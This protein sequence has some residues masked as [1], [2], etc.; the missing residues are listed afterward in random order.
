MS[1]RFIGCALLVAALV[2]CGSSNNETESGTGTAASSGTTGGGGGQACTDAEHPTPDGGCV[3]VAILS[4]DFDDVTVSS[5]EEV[6]GLCQS[7]T[8]ENV[9]EL[10][11]HAVEHTSGAAS[12]HS[13]Y[14]FVPDDLYDGPDGVWPCTDRSYSQLTAALEGGVLFAQSTLAP[15]EI[16]RFAVGGAIRIPPRSR[17]IGESHLLNVT[18]ASVTGHASIELQTIPVEAVTAKLVPFHLS[19]NGLNIPP[20]ATSRFTGECQVA[21][22]LPAG[23]LSMKIHYLLPHTHA[24]AARLFV[25]VLGGASDGES[26]LSIDGFV[27]EGRG[28]TFDPPIAM[29]GADGY[30]F[31]EYMNPRSEYVGWGFGDQEM[32]EILGFAEATHS[33]EA[34]VETAEP[35]GADGEVQLFTGPCSVLAFEW[36]HQKPGGPP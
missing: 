30:R 29:D 35:A 31:C 11:V 33:F 4:H 23:A 7:W 25:D 28:K 16:Q 2:G 27:A 9:E 18:D 20:H 21:A 36:D 5:G 6:L 32:C 3:P 15:H 10:W 14:A 12:H 24:L 1:S 26:L 19:Y 8:L 34:V 13:N 22:E 17:V